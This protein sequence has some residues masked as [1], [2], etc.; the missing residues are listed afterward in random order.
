MKKLILILMIPMILALITSCVPPVPPP[1]PEPEP[2]PS[3]IDCAGMYHVY[4]QEW[5]EC[6]CP[7]CKVFPAGTYWF[8]K[9]NTRRFY[10]GL[11]VSKPIE[12]YGKCPESY[13]WEL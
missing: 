8:N 12:I 5:K 3:P 6:S 1:E 9:I 7:G 10:I 11:P 13:E 2:E 4:F